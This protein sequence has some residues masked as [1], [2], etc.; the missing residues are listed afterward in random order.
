MQ[1]KFYYSGVL[2]TITPLN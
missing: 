2:S 1:L